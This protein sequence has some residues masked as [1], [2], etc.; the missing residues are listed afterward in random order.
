MYTC[1][2]HEDGPIDQL[3]EHFRITF[4]LSDCSD[5]CS[6]TQ[7][8][9]SGTQEGQSNEEVVVKLNRLQ[10]C[11]TLVD[12]ASRRVVTSQEEDDKSAFKTLLIDVLDQKL[13]ESTTSIKYLALSCVWG[14][15]YQF[16]T[17]SSQREKLAEKDSLKRERSPRIVHDAV[18][19][20]RTI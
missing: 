1:R 7:I 13:V 17:T 10:L 18:S 3:L 5:T 9:E 11:Q 14:D 20:T 19:F 6:A 2:A 8:E 15:K 16:E 4:A 12:T